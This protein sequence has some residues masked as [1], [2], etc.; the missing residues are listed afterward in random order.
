[1]N[2]ME[3]WWFLENPQVTMGFNTKMVSF[4]IIWGY[5]HFGNFHISDVIIQ[6][7]WQ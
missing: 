7:V 2:Y 4:W 6:S 1:M 3:I 5:P